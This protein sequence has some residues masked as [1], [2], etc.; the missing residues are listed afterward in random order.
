M[1]IRDPIHGTLDISKNEI[2]ILDTPAFQRLRMIKQLGFSEFS[3]PG[4]SHS[5]YIHSLGVSYLS[6]V[7]FDFI[8]KNYTF[9]SNEVRRNFRQV[10]RLGALLHDIGHGPLSHTTEEVMP[11]LKDLAVSVYKDKPNRKANHEDYTIKFIL[12][13]Q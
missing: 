6:G 1:E 4:A 2:K 13:S 10:L 3:Y 12:D 9:S 7:A 5:R 11:D 8:F